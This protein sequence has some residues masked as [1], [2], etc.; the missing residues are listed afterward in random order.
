M[1]DIPYSASIGDLAGVRHRAGS[2]LESVQ[3]VRSRLRM[4]Q[5]VGT[6]LQVSTWDVDGFA[7]VFRWGVTLFGVIG[8]L[9]DSRDP[10][11]RLRAI[12]AVGVLAYAL[13]HSC[14]RRG[15]SRALGVAVALAIGDVTVYGAAAY[16]TGLWS[17][18]YAV[19]VACSVAISGLVGGIWPA[20]AGLAEVVAFHIVRVGQGMSTLGTAPFTYKSVGIFAVGALGV[21]G[22][23]LFRLQR[24]RATEIDSLRSVNEVHSLLIELHARAADDPRLLT[25]NG[26][27]QTVVAMVTEEIR[28]DLVTV[29][30]RD[31]VV[32]GTERQWQVAACEGVLLPPVIA[33]HR[34]PRI[35]Q[36]AVRQHTTL[37]SSTL[38]GG[39]GLDRLSTSGLYA[40]LWGRSNLL[41]MLVVERRDLPPFTEDE[42]G[43]VDAIARRAGLAIE[44]TQWFARLRQLGAEEE[45]DRIAREL[46]DRIGQSLAGVGLAVDRLALT[47]PPEVGEVRQE[48]ESVAEDVRGITRQVR[49]KLTD[50]RTTPSATASLGDVLG[51]FLERVGTRAGLRVQFDHDPVPLLSPAEEHEVWR[52]AQ[53]AILNAER[54]SAAKSLGV[55]WGEESGR[56]LLIVRD[57]GVG[58]A[59]TAPP[60]RD[61]YGLIGMRE[62]AE[63]IG[64][65]LRI[66]TAPGRG[67]TV[68]LRLMDATA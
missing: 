11:F 46:H 4:G 15:S 18:P 12:V 63:V 48:L 50:L 33:H 39:D 20:L 44:N 10:T 30:I 23:Q 31:P 51:E 6:R 59:G 22:G 36:A 8:G 57:D 55:F 66:D 34:L 14:A 9:L 37:K 49:D 32:Y 2:R 3:W 52:I 19:S 21:C 24:Q 5:R 1:T 13:L 67:T 47:L 26:A 28:A 17:S 40:P 29:F 42:A 54:H 41:G 68:S 62:R 43:L 7:V 61:A 58:I 25:L 64:A 53:E 45:R 56:R 60:R 65:S 16:F 27:I 35:A 38:A